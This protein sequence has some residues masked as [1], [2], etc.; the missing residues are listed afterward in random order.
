MRIHGE[1]LK[2][3]FEVAQ[4]TVAKYMIKRWEPPS[5]EW[6]TFLRDH[7]PEIATSLA[8]IARIAQL[9]TLMRFRKCH[10][11]GQ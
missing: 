4:S 11:D 6:R 7:T 2:L 3:C 10:R 5:Q 1:L 8:T 9:P